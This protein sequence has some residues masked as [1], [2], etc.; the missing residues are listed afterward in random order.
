MANDDK[1]QESMEEQAGVKQQAGEVA[2]HGEQL[3]APQVEAK[4]PADEGE[5]TKGGKFRFA[6]GSLGTRIRVTPLGGA[7]LFVLIYSGIALSTFLLVGTVLVARLLSTTGPTA[8]SVIQPRLTEEGDGAIQLLNATAQIEERRTAQRL[9]A[10]RLCVALLAGTM[11]VYIGSTLVFLVMQEA[12]RPQP[13]EDQA[14]PPADVV[15]EQHVLGPGVVLLMSGA[16][17]IGLAFR[18]EVNV[19]ALVDG[20]QIDAKYVPRFEFDEQPGDAG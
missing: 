7:S 16:L 18:A 17:L 12:D 15:G 13:A 6:L 14:E 3:P 2:A 1:S 8:T 9:E 19:S 5:E 11:L 20:S 10:A 4:R